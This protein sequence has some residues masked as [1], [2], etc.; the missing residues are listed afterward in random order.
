[1][2]ITSRL[3]H[4][5]LR[6]LGCRCAAR[7]GL[8]EKQLRHPTRLRVRAGQLAAAAALGATALAWIALGTTHRHAGQAE[9]PGAVPGGLPGVITRVGSHRDGPLLCGDYHIS[10][11]LTP[12][13]RHGLTVTGQLCAAN[14]FD[15]GR[16]ELDLPDAG[17]DHRLFAWPDSRY[18]WARAVDGRATL[19]VD[20]LGTGTS[21]K[22]DGRTLTV[23]AQAWVAHQL[24][25]Y[26]RTGIFGPSY[27]QIIEVGS[28]T[29][30]QI[31]TYE[32][33]RWHDV[34]ALIVLDAGHTRSLPTTT[35]TPATTDPRADDQLWAHH[36]YLTLPVQARCAT[37]FYPPATPSAICAQNEALEGH[38][39]IPTG[40]AAPLPVT[41]A[42]AATVTAPVLIVVDARDPSTC[43]PGP[44]TRSSPQVHALYA[45][46]PTASRRDLWIQPN[47]GRL[48]LLHRNAPALIQLINRWIH[49]QILQTFQ[50]P[51]HATDSAT[52]TPLRT[53]GH[54]APP[55]DD[56]EADMSR[57]VLPAH[58]TQT[59]VA[60]GWDPHLATFYALIYVK[61]TGQF[62]SIG[63]SRR[64]IRDPRTILAAVGSQVSGIDGMQARLYTDVLH[65]ISTPQPG[66]GYIRRALSPPGRQSHDTTPAETTSTGDS[67]HG[68]NVNLSGVGFP[69]DRS[70]HTADA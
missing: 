20:P 13:S 63:A 27:Q 25:S 16:A 48:G 9:Q 58:D 22:P 59:E 65:D 52:A 32:A 62:W 47:A 38:T 69:A 12:A 3:R 54:G 36:G 26:L 61:N 6:R 15:T 5:A 44:C 56:L 53:Q 55:A 42:G 45:T 14:G 28:G 67:V 70:S 50:R 39:L 40:L 4:A 18:D 1:M 30:A 29:G 33:G 34:A 21:S 10:V 17:Y 11:A 66:A 57:H 35:L 8:A 31:A 43:T 24:V 51:A 49:H 64:E 7:L 19:A 2:T 23:T 46:F 60:V 41:S 37:G 68:D